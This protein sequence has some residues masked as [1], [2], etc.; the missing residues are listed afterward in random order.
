MPRRKSGIATPNML[1][2]AVRSTAGIIFTDQAGLSAAKTLGTINP[3]GATLRYRVLP[4]EAIERNPDQPRKVFN[5]AALEELAV[6]IKN[7]GVLQ[8]ILVCAK[9]GDRFRIVAGERRWRAA[10]IA[11][12]LTI[13]AVITDD[14]DVLVLTI[15]ENLQRENLGVIEMAEVL[16]K[17]QRE[18]E[19]SQ[20]ALAALIGKSKT[21]VS[22]MLAILDLP[23]AILDEIPAYQDQATAAALAEIAE[24]GEEGAQLALWEAVKAGASSKALRQ[25]KRNGQISVMPGDRFVQNVTQWTQGIVKFCRSGERLGDEH[26]ERLIALRVAIDEILAEDELRHRN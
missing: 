7:K 19:A 24:A 9:P 11:G 15:I 18:H 17:L 5:D 6:S 13:P 14:D 12:Q 4:I 25:A 3:T 26:R 1:N 16:R 10:S 2:R 21:Y 23:R 8:P 20:D 22:R